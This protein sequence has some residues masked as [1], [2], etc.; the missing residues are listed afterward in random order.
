MRTP[1]FR[2]GAVGMST[3]L[4]SFVA[5]GN[6]PV[7]TE[8]PPT[9]DINGTWTFVVDVQRAQG[10]CVGE[11]NDPIATW[12]NIQITVTGNAVQARGVF[13]SDGGNHT[14]SGNVDGSRVVIGGTYPED[15]GTLI[16]THT[17]TIVNADSMAGTEIWAWTDGT[18]SCEGNSSSVEA[19]RQ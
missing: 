18:E 15:M 2:F 8:D 6:D 10:D 13:G 19:F 3:L 4:L 5:C 1:V 9:E 11:Q 7:G 12:P 16:A 14:L 17:L